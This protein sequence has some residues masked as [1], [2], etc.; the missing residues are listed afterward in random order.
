MEMFSYAAYRVKFG[1]YKLYDIQGSKLA[2]IKRLNSR[3]VFT[4]EDQRAKDMKLKQILHPYVG[5]IVDGKTRKKNCTSD[6]LEDCY[7]RKKVA[8][9]F[10]LFKKSSENLIIGILGGSFADGTARVAKDAL[11]KGFTKSGLFDDRAVQ[12]YNLANGGYKQPQQLMHLAYYYSMGAEFDIVINLDGFNELPASYLGYRDFGLHPSFPVH[13]DNRVA[14]TLDPQF[15]DL[16]SDKRML[17]KNHARLAEFWLLEGIRYSPFMNFIWRLLDRKN[18]FQLSAIDG[19]MVNSGK[20]DNRDFRYEALGPDFAF[21]DWDS[22]FADVAQIWVDSSL[23]I[24]AIAEGRGARYYHFLQP[25]QY[26]EGNKILSKIE[27]NQFV[28]KQGGYGNVY[29]H[30]RDILVEKARQLPSQGV[31][32][33]DLTFAFKDVRATLY[34]DNCCHMNQQGYKLVA[35][36][37]VTGNHRRYTRN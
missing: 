20:T 31:N 32:Y 16:Y 36:E 15:M 2:A 17:F 33:T 1:E 37:I 25:N 6:V 7:T 5:Y 9:D 21:T 12:V 23:A 13:W 4:Q 18:S 10:P 26:I 29:D 3:G 35:A 27:K 28:L 8:T 34:S 14:K 19:K 11:I 22:F 30:R 24:H